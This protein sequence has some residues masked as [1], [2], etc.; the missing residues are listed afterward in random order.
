[1]GRC[2]WKQR[3]SEAYSRRCTRETQPRFPHLKD[4][5][6]KQEADWAKDHTLYLTTDHVIPGK[7]VTYTGLP[8]L[9]PSPDCRATSP[10]VHGPH[11]P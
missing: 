6:E 8:G 5:S 11:Q 3:T 1:M 10:A 7:A 9:L 2:W 4:K